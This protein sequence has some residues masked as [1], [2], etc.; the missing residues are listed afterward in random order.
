[1]AR[2]ERS[3]GRPLPRAERAA[4]AHDQ[5]LTLAEFKAQFEDLRDTSLTSEL[6]SSTFGPCPRVSL[7]YMRDKVSLS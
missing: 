3:L 2:A 1:V 5:G 7:G 4:G 6:N